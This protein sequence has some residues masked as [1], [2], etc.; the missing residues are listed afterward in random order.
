VTTTSTA[1][2]LRAQAA[3]AL[4]D[5]VVTQALV[6]DVALPGGAGTLALI[7]LDN[8]LDHTKPSTFGPRGLLSLQ[9]ALDTVEARANAGEIVAVGLT[10]KPFIFA[11]GA[12]LGMVKAGGSREQALLI[13][14]LGHD[15]FRR[16]GELP[17]PSFAYVNG[18]AMGGG[19]EIALHCTYRTLSSGIPAVALPE[20]FLGLVP[21]WG[22]TYLL[23]N[24]IG[25]QKALEV[26]ITNPL[27]Q[28][29]MLN[30]KKAFGIGRKYPIT[31][32]YRDESEVVPREQSPAPK[33]GVQ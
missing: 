6:R 33:Q 2:D 14:K 22:G 1:S 16:L 17:V 21:G 10:G 8:G 9:A 3:A 5:E 32:G 20:C 28:N 30:G 18:A 4:P 11:V 12:D 25:P 29:K 15:Q 26:I 13:G 27:N 31:N 7:T 23:P 19:L 24:L